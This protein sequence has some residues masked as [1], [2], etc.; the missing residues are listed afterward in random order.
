MT[1]FITT[2]N[3][4][5]RQPLYPVEVLL[6][7]LKDSKKMMNLFKSE[8][9]KRSLIWVSSDL[10]E[11]YTKFLSG[12]LSTKD[13]NR[14]YQTL[15]K[16]AIRMTTRSTPF[17]EFASVG[18]GSFTDF[19][20]IGKSN[21]C[22]KWISLDAILEK[23]LFEK[24][25]RIEVETQSPIFKLIL[26]GT[27]IRKGDYR[28]YLC[29]YLYGKQRFV[30]LGNN[31]IL[32]K[33]L[34]SRKK[35]YTFE[36][37]KGIVFGN[38]DIEEGVKNKF[39]FSLIDS[40]ILLPLCRPEAMGNGWISRAM[41]CSS[42]SKEIII[43]I[44]ELLKSIEYS[45]DP[46][47]IKSRLKELKSQIVDNPMS[48]KNSVQVVMYSTGNYKISEDI[49]DK[50]IKSIEFFSKIAP[51]KT[52]VNIQNFIK[53][54]Q[55]RYDQQTIPLLEVLNPEIGIGYGGS[56]IPNTN[57]L[58]KKLNFNQN[59]RY[60]KHIQCNDFEQ[61][62]QRKIKESGSNIIFLTDEDVKNFNHKI[63]ELPASMSAVFNL[64]GDKKDTISELHFSGSSATC[65]IGRFTLGNR[66]V[67]SI[68]EAIAIHEA[69]Y[70]EKDGII[71]EI[72]LLPNIRCGNVN[73]RSRFRKYRIC[74]GSSNS[75]YDIPL[76]D[77]A[78]SIENGLIKLKSL[79]SGKYI[80]PRLSS[81]HN[82]YAGSDVVYQFLGDLQHQN[83]LESLM[84][85]WGNLR[86]NYNHFPRV[87]YY[88]MI[89][90]LE[91][92]SVDT[93]LLKTNN[94][95]SSNRYLEWI[96]KNNMPRYIK[97]IDGDNELFIDN[98]CELAV[99]TL[100]GELKK[101]SR[102]YFREVPAVTEFM[103]SRKEGYM[104]QIII[105]ILR[106]N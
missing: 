9:F 46:I 60:K 95:F 12:S 5:I 53:D 44:T 77:L 79:R 91:E 97:L 31:R 20:E 16:Y 35:T 82:N 38:S 50:I 41:T 17:G 100:M 61:L 101:H 23:S 7:I 85:S 102:A 48:M 81:A 39:I 43:G 90:S 22:K 1:T 4:I 88:D 75:P 63:E 15:L 51:R 24:I 19:T 106:Y 40:E 30:A 33:L 32:D 26:N 84:F 8:K 58:V 6:R 99:K 21:G 65:L 86:Q 73:Y 27:I 49:K 29:S 47:E 89:I 66:R 78:V 70:Y 28:Y 55:E 67:R 71:A 96:K 76:N 42:N 34:N 13:E 52:N 37:I 93:D 54:F 10:Y 18:I 36:E 69:N 56:C 92:W 105:P 87:Y 94:K 98:D 59:L 3:F 74:N 83:K 80:Q 14:M 57:E 25:V 64:I 62:M 72:N 2:D 45:N 104:N 68:A 11:E 103:K